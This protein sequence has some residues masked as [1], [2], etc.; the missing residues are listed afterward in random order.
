[1]EYKFLK[2]DVIQHEIP[3]YGKKYTHIHGFKSIIGTWNM[4]LE[5]PLLNLLI[6]SEIPI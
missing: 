5:N 1:M 2:N 4:I 3:K 6:N